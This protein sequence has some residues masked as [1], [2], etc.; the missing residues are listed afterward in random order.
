MS[1]HSQGSCC[2]R[3]CYNLCAKPHCIRVLCLITIALLF[4]QSYQPFNYVLRYNNAAYSKLAFGPLWVEI[5]SN[6]L[7]HLKQGIQQQYNGDGK[8]KTKDPPPKLAIFSAHDLTILPLLATL[9]EEVWD[10]EDWA[11]YASLIVIEIHDIINSSSAEVAKAY[12]SGQAFRLVYNGDVVTPKMRGCLTNS[13]LCDI[14]ILLDRVLS[15]A[16]EDRDCD[17]TNDANTNFA[18]LC[19][20]PVNDAIMA[21]FSS[22]KGILVVY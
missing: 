20:F 21:L 18:T 19:E 22:W 8:I 1:A 12:P 2:W 17:S 7:P 3:T 5:L 4:L 10:G 6:I 16:T 14:S 11:P 13:D 9:G 15:F